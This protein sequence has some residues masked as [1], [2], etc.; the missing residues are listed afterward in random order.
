M[1]TKVGV[2]IC[3]GCDIGK[4]VDTDKLTEVAT[5]EMKAAVC[6]CHDVL[7]SAEAVGSIRSDIAASFKSP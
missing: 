4:S 3:K 7:C 2:Y 5:D 6:K 1:E